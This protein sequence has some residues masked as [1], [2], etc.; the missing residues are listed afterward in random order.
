MKEGMK[1]V[2]KGVRLKVMK[3]AA[4]RGV[5]MGEWAFLVG[6]WWFERMEGR[7]EG[8]RVWGGLELEGQNIL[9]QLLSLANNLAVN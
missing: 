6:G 2:L 5:M 1:M 3:G 4:M 9:N 7:R 8:R